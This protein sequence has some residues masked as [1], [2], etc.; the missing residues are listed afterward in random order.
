MTI[1]ACIRMYNVAKFKVI[2]P[3]ILIDPGLAVPV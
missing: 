1:N 3:L 2:V